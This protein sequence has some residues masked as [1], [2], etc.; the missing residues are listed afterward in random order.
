MFEEAIAK[1]IIHTGHEQACH[2]N[3]KANTLRKEELVVL[4]VFAQ[5]DHSQAQKLQ[6]GGRNHD[7]TRAKHVYKH[8]IDLR[9]EKHQEQLEGEDP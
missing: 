9:K 1:R 2:A 5:T 6:N 8:A 7:R 3:S 4:V